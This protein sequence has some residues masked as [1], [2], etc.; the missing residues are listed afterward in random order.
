MTV[1]RTMK[2]T[3]EKHGLWYFQNVLDHETSPG[4][5]GH[6]LQCPGASRLC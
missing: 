5:T 6:F 2:K 4:Q 1:L 3:T